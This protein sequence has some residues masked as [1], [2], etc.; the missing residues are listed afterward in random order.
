M[1]KKMFAVLLGFLVG[2][3]GNTAFA[4]LMS[5]KTADSLF[6]A[7]PSFTIYKDNYFITG[8]SL[9]EKPTKYNAD[10]K[11]QISFQQ[12]LT[13][14]VLPFHTYLFLTYTQL[15]FWDVYR[16]SSPFAEINFNP[17]LGLAKRLFAN[18]Q[19]I[20]TARLMLEHESNGRDSIYSRSWNRVSFSFQGPVFNKA[21]LTVKGW[22]PFAYKDD[23]PDILHYE[24]YGEASL[25][26]VFIPKRFVMDVTFRKGTLW[27]WKGSAQTQLYYKF[28]KSDNEYVML[29]WF[30]GYGESLISYKSNVSMLRIGIIIKPGASPIF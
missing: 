30:Q 6:N 13:K 2:M 9:S 26:Y 20:G 27:D 12:L 8:T 14:S 5:K 16:S 18:N 4:Q 25:L 23:N 24:G 17:T 28:F 1:R 21:V 29:Q 11:Y 3:E 10:I 19:F 7:R 22:I 15:A